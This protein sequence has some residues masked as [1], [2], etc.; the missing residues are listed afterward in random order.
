MSYQ[1]SLTEFIERV[2]RYTDTVNAP[3][4]TDAQITGAINASI[5][6]V[7]ATICEGG[8]E[9]LSAQETITFPPDENGFGSLPANFWRL[10]SLTWLRGARDNVPLFPFKARDRSALMNQ[11]YAGPGG[12]VPKYRLALQSSL[13]APRVELCPPLDPLASSG[14]SLLIDYIPDPPVLSDGSP[15]M[16]CLPG[17]DEWI[18]LDTTIGILATE[19]TD[20]SYWVAQRQKAT[21]IVTKSMSL[22][23]EYRNGAISDVD[24]DEGAWIR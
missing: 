23:D 3:T 11:P 24:Q 1:V 20:V 10:R 9:F 22:R 18:V 16:Y 4:P 8:A 5:R 6:D 19:E 12:S 2:R 21:A 14:I 17:L 13:D 7:Y 15:T